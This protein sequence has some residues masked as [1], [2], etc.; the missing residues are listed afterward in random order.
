MLVQLILQLFL[1][2]GFAFNLAWAQTSLSSA[3]ITSVTEPGTT[4]TLPQYEVRSSQPKNGQAF[5]YYIENDSKNIGGPGS[6]QAYT[7]GFKFSYV[8]ADDRVPSW[9][10]KPVSR[11]RF[12]GED[13]Q[14]AKS[15]IGISLGQQI[16]TPRN[17]RASE[18]IKDD[19]PYA[20]WLYMGFASSFQLHRSA[21]FFELDL[22]VV[23]P[24]ALGREVQ[25]N[26]HS[27]IDKESAKGWSNG[28]HDEPTVQLQYQKR[29]KNLATKSMD[30]VSYYGAGLGNVQVSA[31]AGA[32]LRLGVNLPNDFG[33]SRPSAA[34]GD[35]FITPVST[36][37]GRSRLK[38]YYVFSGIRGN[39]FAHNIFLDGNTFEESHSVKKYPFTLETE[40]GA[41]VFVLPLNVVWRMV[42]RSPEFEGGRF[43]GFASLNFVYFM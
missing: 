15:N 37:N 41:G 43:T 36:T 32:L 6:D 40:F 21:H 18:L 10:K 24:S 13:L 28:L 33:P 3:T 20:G 4:L 17:T 9:A 38:S 30:W 8:Y 35:S 34:E 42:S 2:T 22:G 7:N 5:I 14:N 19:R 26:F 39:A 1:L 29:T 25:N 16:Y 23:G 31:H 11:L 12:L 27:L